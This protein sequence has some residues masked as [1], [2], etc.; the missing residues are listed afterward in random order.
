MKDLKI[1]VTRPV[2]LYLVKNK[3]YKQFINNCKE[4]W[5]ECIKETKLYSLKTKKHMVKTTTHPGVA[6][7]KGFNWSST[8]EGY[9]FWRTQYTK[10]EQY[11]FSQH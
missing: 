1:R 2:Y 8:K 11:E 9:K 4:D 6:I 7:V 3:I 5:L 10:A